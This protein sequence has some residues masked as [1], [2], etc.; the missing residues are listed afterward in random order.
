MCLRFHPVNMPWARPGRTRFRPVQRVPT[1]RQRSLYCSARRRQPR[2]THSTHIE[3]DAGRNPASSSLGRCSGIRS[4]P[5]LPLLHPF[6]FNG[7]STSANVVRNVDPL[8]DIAHAGSRV[9][10]LPPY[11]SGTSGAPRDMLAQLGGH[12]QAQIADLACV[13][14]VA[15]ARHS[16]LCD[17]RGCNDPTRR[18][19]FDQLT[20]SQS[21]EMSS[22]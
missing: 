17:S 3:S 8:W 9:A 22:S 2:I 15:Q 10:P 1:A 14:R 19:L 16:G 11:E 18:Y 6:R 4:R 21:I 13:R 5:H 20:R 12:I 7:Q